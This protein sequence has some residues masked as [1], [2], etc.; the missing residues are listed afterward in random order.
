M[1]LSKDKSLLLLFLLLP[2]LGFAQ[3]DPMYTQYIYNRMSINPAYVGSKGGLSAMALHRSQ[4]QGVE[5]APSTQNISLH[6]PILDNEIGLG[7]SAVRDQ[8][9]ISSQTQLAFMACY[10]IIGH[11]KALSFGLS[12]IASNYQH[13]LSQLNPQ[14][15]Q[16]PLL[17][18]TATESYWQPNVGIGIYYYTHNY[19][20]G[21]SIPKLLQHKSTS[22][23]T[24]LGSE[25]VR[26]YFLN[27]GVK[28]NLSDQVKIVPSILFKFVES[29]PLQADISS[30][31]VLQDLIWL[32]GTFRTQDGLALMAQIH[33]PQGFY[34]GYGYDFPLT[35]LN[36][37][38]TGSH[39]IVIGIDINDNNKTKRILSP[40]Y[41]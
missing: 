21:F 14:N 24:E 31:V 37:V 27:G 19:F 35:E 33:L 23:D 4:W 39:E 34:F 20:A 9:G 18:G 30:L 36:T 25:T 8:I 17:Q 2:I 1:L 6:S 7:L 3:Q 16:D 10:R 29:A 28:F 22:T 40:R 26:H 15:P 41:F 32:G 11:N 12:G 38:T 5:G 13:D